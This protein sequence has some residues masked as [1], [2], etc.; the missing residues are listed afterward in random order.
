MGNDWFHEYFINELKAV[1]RKNASKLSYE[2]VDSLPPSGEENIIYFVKSDSGSSN[3]HYDE[4]AWVSSSS[5]FEKI[6]STQIDGSTTQPD[7]NQNNDT[8]P[9]YIKNRPFYEHSKEY[10]WDGV[11]DGRESFEFQHGTYVKVS[12]DTPSAEDI[13]SSGT[14]YDNGV[15]QFSIGNS[16][17][18]NE[19]FFQERFAGFLIVC[20]ATTI[21][22]SKGNQYTVPST[23]I[24]YNSGYTSF[25][26]V[27]NEV[28]KIDEKFL[29]DEIKYIDWNKPNDVIGSIDN[30]PPIY[31]GSGV[32]GITENSNL[33]IASGNFSHAEGSNT[34]ASGN[35]SHAEGS[36]ATSSGGS[37]H[38]EGSSTVASRD[39]SHAE[40]HETTASG[41][42]SHAEGCG[43]TANTRSQHVQGEYNILDTS[44]STTTRG[45]YVHIVGN[46][47]NKLNRSNAHTL[48]WN[49]NAW[50]AGDVYV[51]STSS[52]NKDEGSQKLATEAYV[53]S[54]INTALSKINVA[55]EGAY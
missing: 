26:L 18:N 45:Q 11:A 28:I 19:T 17:Y 52:I 21:T 54:M 31:F 3:N 43:I 4:Y 23:G 40:G 8:Q 27:I 24:Y 15:K 32:S 41:D 48:D 47:I 39:S 42:Y 20:Y 53:N 6:G 36:N 38:A 33:N 14:I 7:W 34:T 5:A 25:Y 9:D 2:V 46:G 44:E 55:E 30:K 10:T 35:F 29:L 1:G 49:G 16:N 22:D 50:F 13:I 51:G 12:S 37:S